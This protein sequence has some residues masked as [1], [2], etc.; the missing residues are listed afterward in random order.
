MTFLADIELRP[1]VS[2]WSRTATHRP[3]L[4][5]S[6]PGIRSSDNRSSRPPDGRSSQ[7]CMAV[8]TQRTCYPG[9]TS[10]PSFQK[11]LLLWTYR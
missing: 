6:K 2:G 5:K 10:R 9:T 3:G 4:G 8:Q 11:D 1:L 7:G